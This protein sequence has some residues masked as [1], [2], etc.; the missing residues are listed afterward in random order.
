MLFYHI[1]TN[2]TDTILTSTSKQNVEKEKRASI[3][4]TD[5]TWPLKDF[6]PPRGGGSGRGG[7]A[8]APCPC[9]PPGQW[10]SGAPWPDPSS[11]ATQPRPLTHKRVAR[12]LAPRRQP[13]SSRTER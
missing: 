9:G 12:L 7:G 13:A 8:F 4:L 5:G 1:C 2:V 6:H 3:F 11:V 10:R